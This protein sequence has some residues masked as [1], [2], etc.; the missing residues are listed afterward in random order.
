MT[1]SRA[2]DNDAAP[3]HGTSGRRAL[4][5]DRVSR[6]LAYVGGAVLGAVIAVAGLAVHRHVDAG[7]PWGLVLALVTALFATT[8]AGI[9]AGRVGAVVLAG[10]YAA[11]LVLTLSSR[12]EGDYLVAGDTLGYA[13]LLGALVALGIGVVATPRGARHTSPARRSDP[14]TLDP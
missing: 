6:P 12:A 11:V 8:A 2:R 7:L 13:F 14:R 5:R 9:L 3:S 10:G 1:S 4:G